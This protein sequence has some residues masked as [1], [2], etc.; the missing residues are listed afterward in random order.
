MQKD[1]SQR[2]SQEVVC[3]ESDSTTLDRLGC[4]GTL[5]CIIHLACRCSHAP[6]Q[7]ATFAKSSYHLETEEAE[8]ISVDRVSHLLTWTRFHTCL[9]SVDQAS[10]D[11]VSHLLDFGGPGF[12]L[13]EQRSRKEQAAAIGG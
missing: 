1:S 10:V 3:S 9:I 12:T 7:K 6:D 4:G 13:A 8:R 5:V 2:H 11:Q